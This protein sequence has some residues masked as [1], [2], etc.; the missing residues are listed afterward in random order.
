MTPRVKDRIK[1]YRMLSKVKAKTRPD[2][3]AGKSGC[4]LW[5]GRIST[6]EWGLYK[7]GTLTHLG[8]R[9]S[10]HRVLW[11]QENGPLNGRYLVNQ[12]GN[13]LCVSP[14]HW[15]AVKHWRDAKRGKTET[16]AETGGLSLGVRAEAEGVPAVEQDSVP[17]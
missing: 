11:E 16:V 2:N 3:S 13:T 7:Y 14:K 1:L 17:V 8:K 9:V 4:R 15:V 6:D 10:P 12:C 5:L